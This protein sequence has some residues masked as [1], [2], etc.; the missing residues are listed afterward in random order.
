MLE[1]YKHLLFVALLILVTGLI[2]LAVRWPQGM[3]KTFSQHAAAQ[4]FTIYYYIGLFTLVLPLLLAFFVGYLIP[5]LQ[6]PTWFSVC[7]IFSML[8]QYA[9]TLIP[10]TGGWKTT[11]HRVLAGISALLLL[12]CLQILL[13]ADSVSQSDKS[14]IVFP[15]LLMISAV[16]TLIV[17]KGQAKHALIIQAMYFAAFFSAVLV[18]TI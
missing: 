6:L 18:V 5:T 2:V 16:A 1:F 15:F 17:M 7:I 10:E 13:A 14:Y 12:P 11:V 3:G 9:C 8:T 4:R